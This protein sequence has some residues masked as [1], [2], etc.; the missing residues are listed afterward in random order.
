MSGRIVKGTGAGG[1][2]D[3]R[4]DRVDRAGGDPRLDLG[5]GR[6]IKSEVASAQEVARSLRESAQAEV[7]TL[8]ESARAEAEQI[9]RE[10][11][12]EGYAAGLAEW[13]E[14]VLDATRREQGRL[15]ASREDLTRLALRIARKVLGR[16]LDA[17]D[18]T[19]G[20]L[21]LQAVR[22]LQSE[23]RIR[24]YLGSADL[25]RIQA[26]RGRIV[27]EIGSHTEIE[28]VQ[29]A[30][31]RSGGCRVETAFGIVDATIETQ[32]RVLE[33]ALLGRKR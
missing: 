17:N 19:T 2:G 1:D 33:D 9:R 6:V 15:D 3:D 13:T 5:L 25:E 20:D 24:V 10:A 22:G 7:K 32:L 23:G 14:K 4:A 16:E 11:R 29:D 21:V 30:Q 26:Q 8:L 28:F 12:E 18:S 31:I 27:D